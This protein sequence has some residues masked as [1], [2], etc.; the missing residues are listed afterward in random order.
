MTSPLHETTKDNRAARK[1][2]KTTPLRQGAVQYRR[3]IDLP[4]LWRAVD[5]ALLLRRSVALL[6]RRIVALLLRKFVALLLRRSATVS[7]SMSDLTRRP[8]PAGWQISTSGYTPVIACGC[9]Q[10]PNELSCCSFLN[11]GRW[12]FSPLYQPQ[13]AC[14]AGVLVLPAAL[15][16]FWRLVQSRLLGLLEQDAKGQPAGEVYVIFMREAPGG[17]LSQAA[18]YMPKYYEL[19]SNTK[20]DGADACRAAA[21]AVAKNGKV[22]RFIRLEGW[23]PMSWVHCVLPS[24]PLQ[25]RSATEHFFHLLYTHDEA[26]SMI[27]KVWDVAH[28]LLLNKVATPV[29]VATF[30][31]VSTLPV[32]AP[33][34]GNK[35]PKSTK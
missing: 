19:S 14:L 18:Y 1:V 21:M 15:V 6:L 23:G 17:V 12:R 33:T 35:R 8:F 4:L 34:E 32:C 28:P 3:R 31:R 7:F 9:T 10:L 30:K 13:A 24:L 20:A 26:G 22:G 2:P 29:V 16:F 25:V 27:A 11:T 5:V